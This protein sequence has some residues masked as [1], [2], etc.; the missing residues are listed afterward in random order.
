MTNQEIYDLYKQGK[1]LEEISKEYDLPLSKIRSGIF[2]QEN[3]ELAFSDPKSWEHQKWEYFNLFKKYEML[4]ANGVSVRNLL[5]TSVMERYRM[6]KNCKRVLKTYIKD[7]TTCALPVLASSCGTSLRNI[8]SIIN[9]THTFF[10]LDM[11]LTPEEIL[12]LQKKDE[13]EH[14]LTLG[15]LGTKEEQKNYVQFQKDVEFWIQLMLEYHLT[16]ESLAKLIS[17]PFGAKIIDRM[18]EFNNNAYSDAVS[19]LQRRLVKSP[20][21]KENDFETA[22]KVLQ[23]MKKQEFL[24]KVLLKDKYGQ[25]LTQKN[26]PLSPSEKRCVFFFKLKY[27]DFDLNNERDLELI[28]KYAD[29]YMKKNIFTWFLHRENAAYEC[30]REKVLYRRH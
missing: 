18:L 15:G 1:S 13:K 22:S 16:S 26:T 11:F 5:P 28:N 23:N 24:Q 3:P 30:Q 17:Y 2:N 25:F 7:D 27:I 6:Y 19:F 14:G 10:S 20:L 29:K 9:N 4:E 8:K 21:Q 12:L